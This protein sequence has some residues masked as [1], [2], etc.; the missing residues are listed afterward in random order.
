MVQDIAQ[1]TVPQ[2]QEGTVPQMASGHGKTPLWGMALGSIGVVYGDIGTS[3][4]YA[5][6]ESLSHTKAAPISAPHQQ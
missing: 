2:A 4:L 1:A 5:L 6:R 3:P